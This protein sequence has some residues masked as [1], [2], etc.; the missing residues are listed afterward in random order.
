MSDEN[1]YKPIEG[2]SIE[3]KDYGI[4]LVSIILFGIGM[5]SWIVFLVIL[6]L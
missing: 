3:I 1:K 2:I 5:I 6:I 4:P